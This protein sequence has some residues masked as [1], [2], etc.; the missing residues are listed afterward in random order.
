MKGRPHPHSTMCD[1]QC[2]LHGGHSSIRCGEKI[3]GAP[4]RASTATVSCRLE[5]VRRNERTKYVKPSHLRYDPGPGDAR[6]QLQRPPQPQRLERTGATPLR[7]ATYSKG[8]G[9]DWNCPRT[10]EEHS[11]GHHGD[12]CVVTVYASHG[13][14]DG[15]IGTDVPLISSPSPRP[16]RCALSSPSRPS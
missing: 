6:S 8:C 15:D 9:A 13:A 10:R 11:A 2:P 12:H 7:R 1:Q 5:K 3:R 4:A 14:R 16:D